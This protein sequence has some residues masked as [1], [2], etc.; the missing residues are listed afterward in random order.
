MIKMK[1]NKGKIKKLHLKGKSYALFIAVW[2]VTT[3]FV[4][5]IS[6]TASNA[7]FSDTETVT[8]T[9]TAADT[10]CPPYKPTNIQPINQQTKLSTIVTL[11][12]K[13]S[14]PNNNQMN[15]S[16]YD[17][18]DNSLMGIVT[19]VE[20]GSNAS[21]VWSNL[22][23]GKTYQWYAVAEDWEGETKSDTWSFTTNFKPETPELILPEN[24]S[25]N[26]GL[27]ADLKVKVSDVD[28]E[29]LDVYFY[30]AK[31]NQLISNKK[32]VTGNVTADWNNLGYDAE[33]EWYVFV[34]DKFTESVSETWC[35]ET[36]SRP[37]VAPPPSSGGS[38]SPPLEVIIENILPVPLFN[39][40]ENCYVFENITFNA[41]NSFDP[42]GEIFN[43]I[44]TFG[45]NTTITTNESLITHSYK[46]PGVYTLSLTITDNNNTQNSTNISIN[47]QSILM[48]NN[49]AINFPVQNMSCPVNITVNV[50]NSSK[51]KNFTI[52][53][54][55]SDNTSYNQSII[56]NKIQNCSIYYFNKTYFSVGNHSF[57][58]KIVDDTNNS[59]S[60]KKYSF[61]ILNQKIQ[62]IENIS[63]Q[64]QNNSINSPV[65][66][67]AL[68][69]NSKEFT[70]VKI[71][72]TKPDNSTYNTSMI[73]YNSSNLYYHNRTFNQTGEYSFFIFCKDKYNNTF[74][75]DVRY[76]NVL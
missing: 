8:N 44:W 34:K 23:W 71:N 59:I 27:N 63:V 53:L 46:K 73:C 3:S 32:N 13:V 42:D 35:F 57:Y 2:L 62:I 18:S 52:H 56:D 25:N 14:D 31:N 33:Y 64:I 28:D 15:V 29:K 47:I 40:S 65:N 70:Q 4:I 45:D 19:N 60:S 74:Y 5:S 9:F 37:Y 49:V 50:T 26:I 66:I 69:S 54:A 48:I 61:K 12:V 24:N 41:S 10:F 39:F 55:S 16:F 67:T 11:E 17:T 38:T 22:K 58:V 30:N 72:L 76:F 1:V 51:I 21:V 36:K 75:S 20:S 43:Y 7:Y 6:F 68:L